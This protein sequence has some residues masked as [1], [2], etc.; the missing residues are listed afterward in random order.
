MNVKKPFKSYKGD[1][2]F[3]YACY[4]LDDSDFVFPFLLKLHNQRY[5][6][7]YDEGVQD[8]VEVDALRKHNIR[9]CDV[10]IV[11]MSEKALLSQYFLNQIE[12]AQ[13]FDVNIY[14]VYIDGAATVEKGSKFFDARVRNIRA[15]EC[16]ENTMFDVVCQ[17]L[18]PC[19]EPEDEKERV[20]TYDELLDEV[21]PN[22]ENKSREAFE[23]VAQHDST[24][25]QE[26][27]ASA[28]D[29]AKAAKAQKLKKNGLAFL[30]A[31]L[32]VG[33][34]I[35]VAICLYFFFGDQIRAFLYPDEVVNFVPVFDNIEGLI[36]L[37]L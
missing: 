17:L 19:Q 26:S 34:M 36:S 6:I 13:R 32:V 23:A 3:A 30:N 7:R 4:A 35:V 9:H 11:F 16:S 27:A 37:L 22:V 1:G 29:A 20:Y 25:I 33:V 5:R 21:Y 24:K 15:D 8:E 28:V 2:K 10:C 14:I 31:V 18:E 12:I